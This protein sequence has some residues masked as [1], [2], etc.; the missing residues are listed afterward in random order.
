M[1]SNPRDS[2]SQRVGM[3]IGSLFSGI[4]G[5]EL[6]LEWSGLGHTVWQCE[7]DPFCRSILAKHWPNV[8]RFE[9]VKELRQPPVVDLV[10]GGFPCQDISSGNPNGRGLDGARSGLWYEFERI[11]KEIAPRWI[12]VENVAGNSSRWVPVVGERMERIGYETL[13]IEIEARY[14]GAPHRRSR[15]F[16]VADSV[17]VKVRDK[18]QRLPSRRKNRIQTKGEAIIV[19]NGGW[20]DRSDVVR[21]NDG[22]PDRLDRSRLKALGNAVV[23]QCAE[24][25]GHVIQ[26][27]RK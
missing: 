25:I 13:P 7:S 27:L 2:E 23:P 14:V 16:I 22:I 1:G 26:E 20:P 11:V 19:D 12:V 9:D 24:I 4:G 5:L 3:R 17:S 6:G 18:Q 8:E 15:V 21:K 10:C